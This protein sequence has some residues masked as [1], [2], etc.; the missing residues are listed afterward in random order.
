MQRPTWHVCPAGHTTP[1]QGPAHLPARH[2]SPALQLTPMHEGSLQKPLAVS[3]CRLPGHWNSP[4]THLATQVPRK[5]TW[6][7][8]HRFPSST[9]PLQSLSTSS[10]FSVLATP[11]CWHST[12]PPPLQ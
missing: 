1:S 3:H 11:T 4:V 10:H 5:Q 6:S 12:V 7:V 9:W 2:T 8:G